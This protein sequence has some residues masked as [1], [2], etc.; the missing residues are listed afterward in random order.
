VDASTLRSTLFKYLPKEEIPGLAE[1][2]LVEK[3]SRKRDLAALVTALVLVSGSDDSGRMADVYSAYLAEADESVVRSSFYDWFTEEMALL[4]TALVRRALELVQAESP[5]LT[6]QLQGVRDWLIVDSETVTLNDALADTFPATSKP[7]GL[8]V[9]KVYSVGRNN[10]VGFSITPARD[11]DGPCL[12]IDESWRG[13]GLIVD[14]GYASLDLLRQCRKYGVSVVLRL[15]NGWKPRQL[16]FIDEDD[17]LVESVGE[18]VLSDLPKMK[19][20]DYDGSAFDMDVALGRGRSRV[21][22]RLV[23]VTGKEGYHWFLTTL[24]RGT[25]SPQLVG[26]LYRVRWEIEADNRRDK[27]GA[28]L[29]QIRARTVNSVVTLVH[30]SLLRTII[31]NALTHQDLLERPPTRPPLHAFAVIL[32]LCSHSFLAALAMTNDHPR[33]WTHLATLVRARGHD[34]NWR[35]RPSQLDRLRGTTAPRGR[36]RE[37]CLEDCDPTARA[38]KR[39]VPGHRRDVELRACAA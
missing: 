1:V 10:M 4:M 28:R 13:L 15:K 25:H 22:V 6:G 8:K 32:T 20:A 7:A 3:R 14:L 24:P 26:S 30:A 33:L 27:G 11:H 37:K 23:G 5:L 2:F 34:P 31:A 18:P 29:D 38:F 21:E 17:E 36:P 16:R 35:R 19:A 39:D 9:H 12:Q